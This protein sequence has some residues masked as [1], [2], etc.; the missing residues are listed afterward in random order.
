M[1]NIYVRSQPWK[2]F[3]GEDKCPRNL[4]RIY[5]HFCGIASTFANGLPNRV[6]ILLPE[7]MLRYFSQ[8]QAT[9]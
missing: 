7:A 4:F 3:N 6:D 8:Y 1:A 2:C 5:G 9:I